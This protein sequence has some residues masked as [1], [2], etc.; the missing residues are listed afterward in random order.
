MGLYIR[1]FD[2]DGPITEPVLMNGQSEISF[3]LDQSEYSFNNNAQLQLLSPNLSL[4]EIGESDVTS[5]EK[6]DYY[7][8]EVENLGLCNVVNFVSSD[9]ESWVDLGG[10]ELQ[11]TTP[12]GQCTIIVTF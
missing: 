6:D 4:E 8:E 9:N 5:F 2:D 12:A 11:T 1:L 10:Q 3:E 7:Q